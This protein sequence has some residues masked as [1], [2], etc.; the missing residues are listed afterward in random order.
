[1]KCGIMRVLQGYLRSAM[2][3][4]AYRERRGIPGFEIWFEILSQD[5]RYAL[6]TMLRN[7]RF[8]PRRCQ[9]SILFTEIWTMRPTLSK[10]TVRRSQIHRKFFTSIR[11]DSKNS[12]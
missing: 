12:F 7:R 6:R 10:F 4:E 5:L 1:M 11:L 9:D 2:G 3:N 8:H